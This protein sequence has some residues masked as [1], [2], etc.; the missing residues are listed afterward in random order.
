MSRRVARVTF[1]GGRA[2]AAAE[3]AGAACWEL[4]QPL[5]PHTGVPP[6]SVG[7]PAAGC[8]WEPGAGVGGQQDTGG[9]TQR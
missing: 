5:C 4:G 7:P 8:R 1:F 9:A 2:V 6:S 3:L